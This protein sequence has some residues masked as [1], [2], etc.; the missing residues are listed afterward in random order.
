MA[1]DDP[2]ASPL[3]YFRAELK[4]LRERAGMSQSDV[5]KGTSYAISTVSAYERG[6]LIPS[7]DFAKLADKLPGYSI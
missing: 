1:S 6:T 5:A 4:R 3:A 2:Y 7:S